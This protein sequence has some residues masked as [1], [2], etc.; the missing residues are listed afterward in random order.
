[1]VYDND[2]TGQKQTR[3]WT[4]DTGKRRWGALD[5]LKRVQVNAQPMSYRGKDPG[6]VWDH[7]GEAAMR[8]AFK[9]T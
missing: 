5:L 1:M 9:T 6:V 3:G 8:E 4:D 7:G 2:E